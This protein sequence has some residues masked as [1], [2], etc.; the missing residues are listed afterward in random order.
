MAA[1]GYLLTDDDV[2]LFRDLVKWSKTQRANPDPMG[3]PDSTSTE[4]PWNCSDVYVALTPPQGIPARTEELTVTGTGTG[5]GTGPDIGDF[6]GQADCSVWQLMSGEMWPS[7]MDDLTVYNFSESPIPGNIWILIHKDKF[8]DWWAQ[9]GVGGGPGLTP[10]ITQLFPVVITGSGLSMSGET[11][12]SWIQ[13]K[14]TPGGIL[15]QDP[16][17]LIGAWNGLNPAFEL[18]NHQVPAGTFVWML[19]GALNPDPSVGQ[20]Y[21]FMYEPPGEKHTVLRLTISPGGVVPDAN[22]IA[23]GPTDDDVLVIS[24]LAGPPF[25]V[26]AIGGF[27]GGFDDRRLVVT[28]VAYPID[29]YNNGPPIS[30]E[31]L[32]PNSQ[33]QNRIT[34]SDGQ[35]VI[36]PLFSSVTLVYDAQAE[37]GG[38]GTSGTFGAWRVVSVEQSYEFWDGITYYF[39]AGTYYDF[40]LPAIHTLYVNAPGGNVLITGITPGYNGRLITWIND[41]PNQIVFAHNSPTSSTGNRFLF[42]EGYNLVLM[43]NE[44]ITFIYDSAVAYWKILAEYPRLSVR[45]NDN[46]PLVPYAKELTFAPSCAWNLIDMGNGEVQIVRVLNISDGNIIANDVS[47]LAFTP[48]CAWEVTAEGA[49]QATARRLLRFQTNDS[50]GTDNKGVDDVAIASF[51]PACAWAIQLGGSCQVSVQRLLDITNGVATAYDLAHIRL[52]PDCCWSVSPDPANCGVVLQRILIVGT[53]GATPTAVPDVA[54][55]TFTPKCCWS[56][57]A[58][59]S[60]EVLAQRILTVSD[61]Q[62][63]V[64]DVAGITFSPSPKW[65]VTQTSQCQVQVEYTEDLFYI[66]GQDAYGNPISAAVNQIQFDPTDFEVTVTGATAYVR[67]RGFTGSS[68]VCEGDGNYHTQTFTRGLR[69]T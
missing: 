58:G 53:N 49:C 38:P 7:A 28:N 9:P 61:G 50:T 24:T 65:N 42:A 60:C 8:G 6:P 21:E 56:I 43:P 23:L 19:A 54:K 46:I 33:P 14:Y 22:D 10:K 16:L 11:A 66:N 12:Y 5:T 34:T 20:E 57:S 31:H 39:S 2:S 3:Q 44:S 69:K 1:S 68:S 37:N 26:A 32:G 17:G 41:S 30:I 62:T 18:N 35:P 63:T 25:P 64:P 59:Q 15:A 52:T 51:Y 45:R 48:Q 67:T 47:L 4:N 29:A 27:A 40:T 55:I 36:L 13:Q